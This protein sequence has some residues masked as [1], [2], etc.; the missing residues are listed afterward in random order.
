MQVI[1]TEPRIFPLKTTYFNDT[2]QTKLSF[3]TNI[4]YA[5]TL[6]CIDLPQCIRVVC[7]I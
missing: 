2:A 1:P 5:I 7:M 4:A 6:M 3:I